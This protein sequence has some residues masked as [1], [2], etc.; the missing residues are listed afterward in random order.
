MKHYS[1]IGTRDV[2][3]AL[4]D[5]LATPVRSPG[6]CCSS[7]SYVICTSS[8]SGLRFLEIIFLNLIGVLA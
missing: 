4:L 1:E 6:E 5:D 3:P 2:V 7:I 8:L